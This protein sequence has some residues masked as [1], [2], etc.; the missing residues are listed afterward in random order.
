[1]KVFSDLLLELYRLAQEAPAEEFQARVLD[2]LREVLEFDSAFWATG[3]VKP[4]ESV[5]AHAYCLYRQ[6]PDMLENWYR[7]NKE[8]EL[9]FEAFRQ[10][11]QTIN[12]ALC[13]PDWQSR[14][15]P[16]VA[17]HIKRYGMAHCL[18]IIIAEPVL[19][20]WTGVALYRADP[21]R[22]YTEAERLLHQNLTPH[23]AESWN[24][25]RFGLVN[26]TRRSET[27]PSHGRAI[28]DNKGVLYNADRSFAGFMLAEWP[29]WKGPKLPPEL[30]AILSDKGQRRYIGQHT[31]ISVEAINNVELLIARKVSPIDQLSSRERD[32][33]ALFAEG[34][35]YR[36]IADALH[37]APATARNHLQRIYTKL[38]VSNKIAMA[39]LIDGT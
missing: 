37:I 3:V 6:P 32:V 28:C 8:D 31:A 21:E 4:G 34:A 35:D 13:G 9:A 23:L 19:Q 16:E 30:A 36:A 39:R 29:G 14:L 15:G 5:T 20:I 12:A 38:G 25:S 26:S 22:P 18:S 7:I 27:R 24:I 33:A 1:M 11:G 17:E 2:R 10:A